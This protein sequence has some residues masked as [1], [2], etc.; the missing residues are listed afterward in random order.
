[1]RFRIERLAATLCIGA[2][3]YFV[4]APVAMIGDL[5]KALHQRDGERV[6]SHIDFKRVRDSIL[7]MYKSA[8]GD[9]PLSAMMNLA[10]LMT[11]KQITPES[12]IAAVE[13]PESDDTDSP[14]NGIK[15]NFAQLRK[16]DWDINYGLYKIVLESQSK[17][18]SDRVRV[19]LSRSGFATWKIS[20]IEG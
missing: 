13:K 17:E 15:I 14:S 7:S 12:I 2:A 10:V 19:I 8:S 1:M 16:T 20:G 5:Q 3:G 6:A 11:V 9:T 18:R 4:G